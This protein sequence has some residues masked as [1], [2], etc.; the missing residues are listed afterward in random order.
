M[1]LVIEDLIDYEEDYFPD[2]NCIGLTEER[3]LVHNSTHQPQSPLVN[4]DLD[5]DTSGS[6]IREDSLE[7][8]LGPPPAIGKKSWT[9]ISES[10]EVLA[11]KQAS[12]KSES[13]VS[14]IK[15][16]F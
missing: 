1:S 12:K 11:K 8:E 15:I 5:K 4:F 6:P 10:R 7:I 3:I 14:F 16:F 9:K 13:S 2:N